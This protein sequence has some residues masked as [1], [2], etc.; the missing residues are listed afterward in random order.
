MNRILAVTSLTLLTI[1]CQTEV[2]RSTLSDAQKRKAQFSLSA[3]EVVDDLE[4]TLFAS[5]P[6]LVN[7]TNIDVDHRG[8]V[9]V[10][11][12]FNYRNPL[13]PDKAFKS[14]GDRIVI[15]EDTNGDGK[16]DKEKTF[17]QGIDVNAALGIC[18]L[19]N[20]VIVSKSPNILIFTD[21][22][23]DDV[24]DKKE[25]LFTGMDGMDHDHGIHAFTFGPDGKL[26][27]NAGNEV[28][29]IMDK[30]GNPVIDLAGNEVNSDGKPYRQGMAFRMDLDS[31]NLETIGWNFRNPYELAVDSYGTI[32]QSDNDDDGNKGT[33][34][35]FL[36]EFGNYGFSSELTGAS[37]QTKRTGM[38]EE[39]PLR[40]WHLNDPGAVPNLLQNNAGSPT[41]ILVYEGELLPERY[42]G[43]M[44]HTDAGPNVVRSYPVTKNNAG[45]AASVIPI[46]KAVD[47]P[48]FRPS[49]VCVAPD[50]SLIVSDWY[51]PGVGGHLLGDQEKGRLF[52]IAPKGVPYRKTDFDF[53]SI[54]GLV[55][56]LKS[57]NHATRYLAWTGLKQ[58]GESSKS[59]LIA[60]WKDANP[61][62]QARALWLLAELN[63]ADAI[64][65]GFASENEDLRIVA[66]RIA[67]QKDQANLINHL[68]VLSKD[69]SKQVRREVAIALRFLKGSKASDVWSDLAMQYDG[70]RWYLEALGIGSDLNADACFDSWLS[71]VGDNW[72]Q[73]NNLDIVWRTRAK[74]AIPY[75]AT[76]IGE[77]DSIQQTY[78]Y[79]RSLDFHSDPS[80]NR[81][82][83][84]ILDEAS[85]KGTYAKLIFNHIDVDYVRTSAKLKPILYSVIEG[86]RGTDEFIETIGRYSLK[87]Y[88]SELLEM[89]LQSP[90]K[91]MGINAARM[92]LE[93]NQTMLEKTLVSGDE[94]QVSAV[95]SALGRIGSFKSMDVIGGYMNN[96]EN[97]LSLRKMAVQ[98]FASGWNGENK[99]LEILKEGTLDK[100][101]ESSAASAMMGAWRDGVRKE[102]AKY[103]NMPDAKNGEPLPPIADLVGEKGDIINGQLVF[104]RLCQACHVVNEKGIDF[105]P[106]LSEIGAKLSKEAMYASIL[107]P[108]AGLNFGYETYLITLN[109]DTRIVGLISS[110]SESEITM[111]LPGG[112]NSTYTLSDVKEIARQENSMMTPN[113]QAAM[114]KTEIVDLVE[115]LKSLGESS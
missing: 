10:C 83:E 100:A 87:T 97:P 96:A 5:E 39:I 82:M 21:E 14:E 64:K 73:T 24:A 104:D 85:D 11:E 27:F 111:K 61:R 1:S 80:K 107:E 81:E 29:R 3:M 53:D 75:I 28:I 50:G 79:F 114:T 34:V 38:S 44:I 78:R 90:N 2:D 8:R 115:F 74:A 103:V 67:R 105:G 37:W 65:L 56:G 52:R 43:Q 86:Y 110:R 72:N 40:H 55:A 113:L 16:A 109:D 41:G 47:D 4:M 12:G 49:D 48:W 68:S 76:Q 54:D 32:W 62:F 23:G 22:D 106:A 33:R 17:Y 84:R 108:D 66:L 70:D 6:M 102:A 95:L 88:D 57:P 69:P 20:R 94:Q 77:A 42:Q 91:S 15:L 112:I 26:Y 30:D 45:Y 98:S 60:M 13:N 36:M 9:W 51:D 92:L 59:A 71:K 101:L 18:V 35:N 63:A 7:P 99:M 46:A 31:G 58:K 89:V 25:V 19:G 93:N